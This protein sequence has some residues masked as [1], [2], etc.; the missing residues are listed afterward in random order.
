MK[1]LEINNGDILNLD[2][3]SFVDVDDTKDNIE[4][5]YKIALYFAKKQN[6]IPFYY[7]SYADFLAELHRLDR[8]TVHKYSNFM[9]LKDNCILNLNHLAL[10]NCFGDRNSSK[11]TINIFLVN[12]EGH[13]GVRYDDV[14]EWEKDKQA[15]IDASKRHDITIV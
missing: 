12:R 4:E 5:E 9:T 14:N 11:F 10:V 8:G 3:L 7:S 1:I 6:Q 2:E 13:I 15:I